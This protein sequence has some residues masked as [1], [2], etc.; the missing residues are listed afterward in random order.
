MKKYIDFISS[1]QCYIYT[2]KL[3]GFNM[4]KLLEYKEIK[5]YIN[6][7]SYNKLIRIKDISLLCIKENGKWIYINV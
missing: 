1:N 4:T 2:N 7:K 5:N 6:N 3:K